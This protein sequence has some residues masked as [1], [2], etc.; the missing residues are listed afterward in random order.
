MCAL[1]VMIMLPALVLHLMGI[2]AECRMRVKMSILICDFPQIPHFTRQS[3]RLVCPFVFLYIFLVYM[4]CTLHP[5][6][7]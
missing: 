2:H 3:H 4:L 6:I 7:R 1:R 5:Y